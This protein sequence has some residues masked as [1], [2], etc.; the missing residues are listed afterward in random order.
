MF[1]EVLLGL[2]EI[3][4]PTYPCSHDQ[5]LSFPDAFSGFFIKDASFAD[6]IWPLAPANSWMTSHTSSSG[7]TLV[8]RVWGELAVGI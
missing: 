2:D 8:A 7:P 4:S 1:Y 5:Y 3:A 6:S